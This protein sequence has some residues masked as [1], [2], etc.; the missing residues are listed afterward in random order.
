MPVDLRQ[1]RYFLAI[2]DAGALSYA[3]QTLNVAQSALSHHLQE[4]ETNFGVPLVT[5]HPRG[6]TLTPAGQRLYEHARSI[7]SA[8]ARAESDVRAFATSALGPVSLGLTHTVTFQIALSLM[9]RIK[10]E[11]PGV[12]LALVEAM[13][14]S[15]I[16]KLVENRLDIAVAYNIPEDPRLAFVPILK[17]TMHLIGSPDFLGDLPNEVA[18][19]DFLK[20]PLIMP[21]PDSTSRSLIESYYLRNQL[22]QRVMEFDSL[23]AISHALAEGMGCSIMAKSTMADVLNTGRVVAKPIVDPE[24]TRTLYLARS[25][26]LAHTRASSEICNLILR[27]L[28]EEVRS[29]RWEADWLEPDLSAI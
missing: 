12:M 8:V 1:L 6:I 27:I 5:R 15:L 4:L 21:H 20:L 7:V 24:V 14:H 3:A 11:L 2:G 16:E 23:F 26:G 22:P 17:E 18:F 10:S 25:R 29:G 28:G 19:K 9:R 13:S